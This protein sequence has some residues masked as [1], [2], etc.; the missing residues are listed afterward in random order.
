MAEARVGVGQC[1][2]QV[3]SNIML[4][5]SLLYWPLSSLCLGEVVPVSEAGVKERQTVVGH[6]SSCV[7]V[8]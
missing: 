6:I 4:V 8:V 7:R 3:A 2:A 1:P 5:K